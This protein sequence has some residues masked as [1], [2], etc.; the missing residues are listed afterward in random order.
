MIAFYIVLAWL[1]GCFLYGCY[2]G[3]H[4]YK[5]PLKTDNTRLYQYINDYLE[6]Y[7]EDNIPDNEDEIALLE[8]AIER[9]KQAALILENELENCTDEKRIVSLITKLNTL[10][11]QTFNDVKKIEKLRDS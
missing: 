9:R 3:V 2:I 8:I 11:K 7:T 6:D 4:E 5:K 10:D 1:L